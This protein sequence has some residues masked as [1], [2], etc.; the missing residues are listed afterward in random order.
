MTQ[1]LFRLALTALVV[2]LGSSALHAEDLHPAPAQ[3]QG[4]RRAE[5]KSDPLLDTLTFEQKVELLMQARVELAR[6]CASE[7]DILGWGKAVMPQKFHLGYCAELHNYFVSIRHDE[8]TDTEAPRDHAKT[9]IKCNLIPL[10]QALEE[11]NLFDYYL[12][13]QATLPKALAVN[14]AI[15]LELEQNPVIRRLYG[16]QV[17]KDKWTDQLFVLKNGVVFHSVGAGQSIRGTNYRNRRPNYCIVDDLYDE[18]D[19]NNADSTIKKNEWFWST[20]FPMMAEDRKSSLHLQGTAINNE[21]LLKQ[22]ANRVGI[23]YRSFKTIISDSAKLVLWPEL[24]SYAQRVLQR[25]I[26]PAI[27]FEREYQNDRRDDA[28]S[29][30]KSSW[31]ETWEYDPVDLKFD[32]RLMYVGGILGIDPSIG[33]KEENDPAGYVFVLK[34]QRNDGSLPVYYIEGITNKCMT[35]QERIDKAKEY[36]TGRP[37]ERPATKV[38][39]ETISGFKD[40]GD[41]VASNVAVGCDL[42]D[43]VPDKITNLEK[44]SHYFQNHR[45]FLNRNI[46]EFL[47]KEI[48][49]QLTTNH[50]RHDDIRDA[51][52]LALDDES[53]LWTWVNG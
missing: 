52:L 36:C 16:N 2:M 17:G 32:H 19:I 27:I 6:K 49:H 5:A 3:T 40:F 11:P 46:D 12:N 39:V 8:F 26:M 25:N 22:L 7:K 44:K 34:A 35:L 13:V 42:V 51:L 45:V 1:R 4:N 20:L 14:L 38:R 48:K 15:K 31:L 18:E 10:F 9:T 43:K 21:D 41:L 37:N 47:K 50:P 33:Q 28:S 30:V 23:K 53:A 24:K 29:I